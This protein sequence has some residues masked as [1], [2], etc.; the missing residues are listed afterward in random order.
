[1]ESIVTATYCKQ[2]LKENLYRKSRFSKAKKFK[3]AY[4][5]TLDDCDTQFVLRNYGGKCVVWSP[6]RNNNESFRKFY[7]NRYETIKDFLNAVI[8]D[9]DL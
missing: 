6:E 5:V 9:I 7:S 8:S 1:M 2:Q 3:D 4:N